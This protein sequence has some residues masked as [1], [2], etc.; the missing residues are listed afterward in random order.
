M[1]TC[2]REDGW[3]IE[4]T[5]DRFQVDVKTVRKW[6]DRYRDEGDEGQL[7]RSS[8]NSSWIG[9]AS[10]LTET[11]P[12]A[13]VPPSAVCVTSNRGPSLSPSQKRYHSLVAFCCVLSVVTQL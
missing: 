2:V 13:S 10:G 9:S 1:V 8:S 4:A 6:R 11:E 12:M 3:T 5:A 7:D